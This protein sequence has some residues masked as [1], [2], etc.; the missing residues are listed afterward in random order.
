MN[1]LK[2]KFLGL[3]GLILIVAVIGTSWYNLQA[4]S[5]I[6]EKMAAGHARLVAE[7]VH[8]SIITDMANGRNEQAGHTLA[9]VSR[10]PAIDKLRIFDETGRVIIASSPADVGN[11]VPTADLLAFRTGNYSF[12]GDSGE[13]IQ[14][15]SLI[16]FANGPTCHAC[17][18]TEKDVLGV[19]SVQ[20]SLDDLAQMQDRS[21][22]AT[23]VA[24]GIMLVVLA[25]SITL[26]LLNYVDAPI[27]K[28]VAA[29]D[30]AEHGNFS[31]LQVDI[32]NSTEMALL[33]TNFNNMV[34]QLH[35][36]METSI[37]HEREFAVT[38]EK[39]AHSLEL[40]ALNDSLEERLK[41]IEYLNVNLEERIEEIEEAN[42]K[43]ADL[44]SELEVKNHR[45]LQAIERLQTLNQIGLAVNAVLNLTE[46]LDLLNQKVT[47]MFK[48]Q[49]GYILLYDEAAGN[50]R[51]AA[52]TGLLE[53]SERGTTVPFKQGGVS[54]EAITANRP[55]LIEDIEKQ[56]GF[57][58]VSRFGFIRRSV[59]C[60]PLTDQGKV[61]G[62]ITVDNPLDGSSF[63]SDD[64]GL[65]TTIAAQASVAIRNAKLYSEQEQIYLSTVQ[66]LVFAI[67]A[68][69]AYTRGH[70]ERVTRLSMALGQRLEL[71]EQSLR[72]LERAAT[73]HDIGKIG[74]DVNILH[75]REKLTPADIEVLKQHPQIGV[76][77]LDPIHFLG[78][79]RKIIEQ[80]HERHDGLGYPQGLRAEELL[81][82]AKI[83]AVCD[84]YDAMTSDRPY[85]TSLSHQ[86]AI[87]ELR[88]QSG[89]Q[90]DPQVAAAFISMRS[91]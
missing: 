52:A 72:Q 41:E 13:H 23:M 56:P 75:K 39:L 60:A 81:L 48:G 51:I 59:I 46:L 16:P 20:L 8:N 12:T 15:N 37:T 2:L 6:L 1:S 9:R 33:S 50:L 21:R 47:E 90:F 40:S 64:L 91:A 27:R 74:I 43:I 49:V 57:R 85:R 4:Q 86:A 38:Q 67:E 24:S 19:L 88:D 73:L 68:N 25:V 11:L 26:F 10:E 87:Q 82:E 5:S 34:G 14:Y 83:L 61:I 89:R 32:G 31:K 78:E 42:F 17:H 30:Q 77:I 7:T 3:T 70:S 36:L 29:M 44:A 63:N 79:E 18:G 45:L 80:H 84:A 62:T 71:E 76:R 35:E 69:D 66:A 53:G 28:L 55:I 65:L 58:K 54:Y 22:H